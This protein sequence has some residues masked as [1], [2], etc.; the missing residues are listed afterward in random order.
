MALDDIDP[1][2]LTLN[3]EHKEDIN[4]IYKKLNGQPGLFLFKEEEK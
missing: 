1:K 4:I 2:K 3:W